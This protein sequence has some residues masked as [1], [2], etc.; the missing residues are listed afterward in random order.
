MPLT[1]VAIEPPPAPIAV[2]ST[3]G[4]AMWYFATSVTALTTGLPSMTRPTSK[5]VPPMSE[6]MMLRWPSC[7]A[8]CWEPST[9]PVG[10]LPSSS[11]PRWAASRAFITPPMLLST[12]NRPVKPSSRSRASRLSR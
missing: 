3:I 4:V 5:L 2:M 9:P 12:L 1:T 7:A 10:P 6:V 11:T 8:R